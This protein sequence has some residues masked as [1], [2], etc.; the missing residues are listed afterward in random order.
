MD[1]TIFRC[2]IEQVRKNISHDDDDAVDLESRFI[3]LPIYYRYDLSEVFQ[4]R[5]LFLLEN[6]SKEWSNENISAIKRLLLS[7]NWCGEEFIKTLELISKSHIL[8][9]LNIFPELLDNWFRSDF[10]DKEKKLPNI[11]TT[12]IKNLS[13]KLYTRTVNGSSLN[14]SKFIFLVF[15]LLERI[16]PLLGYR[17]NIWQSLTDTAIKIVKECSEVHIFAATI[18]IVALDQDDVKIL[19]SNFVKEILNKTVQQA[20]DELLHNVFVICFHKG[21][22]LEVPNS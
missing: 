20:N 13:S 5:T 22:I 16:H 7:L 14:D 4:S 8:E 2:F 12:W 3:K 21:E 10:S 18:L 9:L 19:F 1:K 11:C 17:I 6:S 15:Q